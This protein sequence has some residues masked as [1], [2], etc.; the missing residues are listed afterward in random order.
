[1]RNPTHGGVKIGTAARIIGVSP[2]LLRHYERKR[3]ITPSRA[4]ESGY[5]YYSRR[6]LSHLF[7]ARFL[8]SLGFSISEVAELNAGRLS[9]GIDQGR[10]LSTV[11]RHRSALKQR[12]EREQELLGVLDDY[13]RQVETLHERIDKFM[14]EYNPKLYFLRLLRE[15][16]IPA[17]GCRH[18]AEANKWI[19]LF[20]ISRYAFSCGIKSEEMEKVVVERGFAIPASYARKNNIRAIGPVE[21]FNPRLCVHTVLGCEKTRDISPQTFSDLM[22]FAADNRMDVAGDA[23]G[24]WIST[25]KD[26]NTAVK[27]FAV[28]VPIKPSA[29]KV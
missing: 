25:L 9:S 28:W 27:Y 4:D 3:L 21:V 13:R 7:K 15:D 24:L 16:D 29:S 26:A 5:R 6:D 14:I 19:N 12:I 2:E 18:Y 11:D 17:G 23:M 8:M 10:W 1:M 22:A 20:P